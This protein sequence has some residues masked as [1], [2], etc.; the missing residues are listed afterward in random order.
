MLFDTKIWIF[1]LTGG[2]VWLLLS[3][4]T[5]RLLTLEPVADPEPAVPEK[6]ET[7]PVRINRRTLMRRVLCVA[8]APILWSV[9]IPLALG[10]VLC[11]E[12]LR[13]ARNFTKFASDARS[14]LHK[15]NADRPR[16]KAQRSLHREDRRQ[17]RLR[18]R[19]ERRA[20]RPDRV[21]ARRARFLS[22]HTTGS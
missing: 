21:R 19:A 1:L 14:D 22:G 10:A 7:K 20:S 12:V 5:Y 11:I 15:W 2:L 4:A 18:T 9:G 6:K 13:F 8:F 3:Y 16:R 17:L